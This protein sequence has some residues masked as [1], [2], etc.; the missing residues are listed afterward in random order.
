[1]AQPISDEEIRLVETIGRQAGL[2]I[3]VI[4]ASFLPSQPKQDILPSPQITMSEAAKDMPPLT[5]PKPEEG[6]VMPA[7]PTTPPIPESAPPPAPAAKVDAKPEPK[8][9]AKAEP[10]PA[11]KPEA[12]P[13]AKKE[14]AKPEPKKEAPKPEAKKDAKVEAKPA[15]E[16]FHIQLG[17]FSSADN[18]KQLQSK[19]S[20]NG[21]KSYTDTLKDGASTKVRVRAGPFASKAEADK[22][23]AKLKGLGL[24]G[25]V[26]SG[27]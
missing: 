18:A 16:S 21:I 7:V 20:A 1:M 4:A 12:K 9:E 6:G 23:L 13:E 8:P 3:L 2:V 17:A 22:A 5:I 10:Q 27:K 14:V 11:A 25:K 24:D 26:A 15:G 19:L